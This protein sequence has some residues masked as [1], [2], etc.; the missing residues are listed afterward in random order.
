MDCFSDPILV[1]P[2]YNVEHPSHKGKYVNNDYQL[3]ELRVPTDSFIEYDLIYFD[4]E[5]GPDYILFGDG[6]KRKDDDADRW[7]NVTGKSRRVTK[8]FTSSYII[9]IFTSDGVNTDYGFRIEFSSVE[10]NQSS[11]TSK[12]INSY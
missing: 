10:R 2:T 5:N 6:V 11:H 12:P 8:N 4:T 1:N 7:T 9:M 3:W